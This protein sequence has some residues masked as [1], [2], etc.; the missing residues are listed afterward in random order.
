M[1]PLPVLHLRVFGFVCLVVRRRDVMMGMS[2]R[3]LCSSVP[4]RTDTVHG[5]VVHGIGMLLL[6]CTYGV[7]LLHLHSVVPV[8]R[9]SW[10][11]PSEVT[12]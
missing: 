3:Y 10:D 5:F 9:S 7:L 6:L 11:Q 1:I 8:L 12:F 4:D 2:I